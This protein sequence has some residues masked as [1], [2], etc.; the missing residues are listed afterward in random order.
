[1]FPRMASPP[2]RQKPN[3]LRTSTSSSFGLAGG[4]SGRL[5]ACP[6][7]A[8]PREWPICLRKSTSLFG[9]G[10]GALGGL[11]TAAG[12][13]S[14]SAAASSPRAWRGIPSRLSRVIDPICPVTS[15]HSSLSFPS[16]PTGRYASL[17]AA[18]D[19]PAACAAAMLFLTS[20]SPCRCDASR[21]CIASSVD[22]DGIAASTSAVAAA[23][24]ASA[25]APASAA[26][27]SAASA[28]STTE[29]STAA[30]FTAASSAPCSTSAASASAS[31]ASMGVRRA[32]CAAECG[33]SHRSASAAA[34]ASPPSSSYGALG[35][36]PLPLSQPALSYSPAPSGWSGKSSTSSPPPPPAAPCRL[37]SPPSPSTS[38]ILA[39][40]SSSLAERAE[41][42]LSETLPELDTDWGERFSTR[43][44]SLSSRTRDTTSSRFC[45]RSSSLRVPASS[46]AAHSLAE[47]SLAAS[48][49]ALSLASVPACAASSRSCSLATTSASA[50]LLSS[51]SRSDSRTA[52]AA[53]AT[54]AFAATTRLSAACARASA[55]AATVCAVCAALNARSAA[56]AAS[57]TSSASSAGCWLAPSR[58]LILAIRT[59][60]RSARASSSARASIRDRLQ[61]RTR[62]KSSRFHAASAWPAA[63]WPNAP[64]GGRSSF[65]SKRAE[66]LSKPTVRPVQPFSSGR[67]A[68]PCSFTRAKRSA[69]CSSGSSWKRPTSPSVIAPLTALDTS[70]EQSSSNWTSTPTGGGC[71]GGST[72]AG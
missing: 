16:T 43:S 38:A 21:L 53:R 14:P 28:A 19:W 59:P 71:T 15:A 31:G 25:S 57:S 35:H 64:P 69:C 12:L 30:P 65:T 20:S 11:S 50:R 49:N 60:S 56:A 18:K 13:T 63:P 61:G 24:L 72:P 62:T 68:S 45:R 2:S 70:D 17:K 41:L 33:S 40:S 36:P 51:R 32:C 6:P 48:A 39:A 5:P 9:V 34:L 27:A 55:V 10:G 4:A 47:R 54:S 66:R 58:R 3:R 44:A 7:S 1:M 46:L 22:G 26:S 29:A 8:P 52:A 23:S 67:A 37:S 42:D